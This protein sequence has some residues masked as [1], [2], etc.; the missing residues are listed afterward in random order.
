MTTAE[1]AVTHRGSRP[2]G[3]R[4]AGARTAVRRVLT[5][6][7]VVAPADGRS[8]ATPRPRRAARPGGPGAASAG[9]DRVDD[10]LAARAQGERGDDGAGTA[11]DGRSRQRNGVRLVPTPAELTHPDGLPDDACAKPPSRG[12]GPARR[13]S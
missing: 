4:H 9:R 7:P 5:R 2:D 11:R 13:Q 1:R 12:A 6:C 3:P 8:G 10:V